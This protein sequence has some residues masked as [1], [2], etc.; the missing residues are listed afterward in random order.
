VSADREPVY[1]VIFAIYHKPSS[2]CPFFEV[3]EKEGYYLA[4]CKVLERYLTRDQVI[5]CENYWKTC[6]YKRIGE[7][8][9][10][11]SAEGS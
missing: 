7:Q 3:K 6:P 11:G 9:G 4:Y 8:M 2:G 5:K 1:K 10:L